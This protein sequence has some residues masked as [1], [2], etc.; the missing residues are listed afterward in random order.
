MAGS[1]DS[2]IAQTSRLVE[3][4]RANERAVRDLDETAQILMAAVD[5]LSEVEGLADAMGSLAEKTSLVSQAADEISSACRA[6]DGLVEARSQLEG[7]TEGLSAVCE[8]IDAVAAHVEELDRH[9]GELD[10]RLAQTLERVR[11]SSLDGMLDRMDELEAKIDR[12]VDLFS[13]H[14][15]AFMERVEPQ[16]ARLEDVA[17]R[18]DAPAMADELADVLATNHQLFE[19]IDAIRSESVEAQEYWDALIDDWHHRHGRA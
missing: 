9:L 13:H 4:A 19:A 2:F 7:A 16:V 6:A 1:P 17:Q 15:E 3:T 18:M 8:R 10:G 11:S 14:G 5:D 12:L